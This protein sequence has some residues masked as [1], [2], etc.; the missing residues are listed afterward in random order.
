M[1]PAEA[2]QLLFIAIAIVYVC[3]M[4]RHRIF[5]YSVP[6]LQKQSESINHSLAVLNSR[7]NLQAY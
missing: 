4:P 6:E 1:C 2:S 5:K 7:N 3:G